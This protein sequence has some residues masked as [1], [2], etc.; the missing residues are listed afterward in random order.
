MVDGVKP[1]RIL[2]ACEILLVIASTLVGF[3]SHEPLPEAVDAYF[4]GPGA[5]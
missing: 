3:L 1:L 4:D 2:V 5:V